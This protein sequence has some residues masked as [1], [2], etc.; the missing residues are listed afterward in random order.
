MAADAGIFS[1]VFN[2]LG[3]L[4]SSIANIFVAKEQRK[5][6]EAAKNA[7]KELLLLQQKLQIDL[8]NAQ[9]EAERKKI[10]YR[11]SLIEKQIE[12]TKEGRQI[13]ENTG[14]I[15]LFLFI[16]FFAFILTRK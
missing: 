16:G 2:F 6:I 14:I 11:L 4:G 3:G 13:N 1:S 7:Q 5:N 12:L 8:L 15:A 9:T 10:I